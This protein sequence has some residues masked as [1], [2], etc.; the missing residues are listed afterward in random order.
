MKYVKYLIEFLFVIIFFALFKI[1]GPNNSSNLSGKL[2][3]KIGHIFRPKK[4][5]HSNIKRAFPNISLVNLEKMT[6]LMWNNYG[7]IFAEYIFIKEFRSGKLNSNINIEGQEILSEMIKLDKQVV[8]VSGHMSNFELM[9]MHLEKSGVK[10]CAI[11]RPLNNI[12]LNPIMEFI[13]K[14]YICENQIKKGVGGLKKLINYKKKNYSTALMIDQRVSEG[15]QSSFFKDNA[16][17]TTIPAQL[18]KKF[19][20]PVVPINIERTDNIS[21]KI[22]IHKP[23][24]FSKNHSIQDITDELNFIL[25]KMI[26]NKP[27]YWIWSHNR[28]K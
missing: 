14:K 16:L 1:L 7:R 22:T 13:R 5:I 24:N 15:I 28:W 12:F 27:E 26:L 3:E 4:L 8:F 2:F 6:Q 10:L 23:V 18:V 19:N 21:F 17:T 20:I 11:Y 9:A 25:E